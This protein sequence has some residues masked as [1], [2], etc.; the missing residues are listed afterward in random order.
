MPLQRRLPKRGFYNRFAT[1][2]QVLNLK[3]LERF[4]GDQKIDPAALEDA[5]LVKLS[6]GP[7]K[8]LAGGEISRPLEI[9]VHAASQ[10]AKA[11]IEAA[12]GKL[13]LIQGA[14]R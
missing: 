12:G 9:W 5:G 10:K 4:S 11:K 8:V 1:R 13:E 2:F 6:K 14:A 7:I 3:D